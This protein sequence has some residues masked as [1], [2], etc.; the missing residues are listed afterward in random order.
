MTVGKSRTTLLPEL[1]LVCHFTLQPLDERLWAKPIC[2]VMYQVLTICINSHKMKSIHASTNHLYLFP[3]K[4]QLLSLPSTVI[5][6]SLNVIAIFTDTTLFVLNKNQ[7]L[8]L[9]LQKGAWCYRDLV[10]SPGESEAIAG[11]ILARDRP[12]WKGK[13]TILRWIICCH[14]ISNISSNWKKFNKMISDYLT[15]L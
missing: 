12:V 8:V 2:H 15:F 9:S 7:Q 11:W 4:S 13:R 1:I 10:N 3:S 6:C 14:L 5:C